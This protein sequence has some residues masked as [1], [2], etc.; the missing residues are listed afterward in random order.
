MVSRK[1][2]LKAASDAIGG[3]LGGASSSGSARV[4]FRPGSRSEREA[5]QVLERL[6]VFLALPRRQARG[7]LTKAAE[8]ISA[9]LNQ[10]VD[11]WR[12]RTWK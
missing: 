6:G 12:N 2:K 1:P 5:L 4:L 11:I 7:S 3:A 9:G 10:V 8:A